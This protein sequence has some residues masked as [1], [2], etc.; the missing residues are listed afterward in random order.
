MSHTSLA[1]LD[2]RHLPEYDFKPRCAVGGDFYDY[3]TGK[4]TAT[5]PKNVEAF[6][7]LTEYGMRYDLAAI[8]E[9]YSRYG[10]YY[11]ADSALFQGA[12]FMQVLYSNTPGHAPMFAPELE[13]GHE[14]L[15][16]S[17]GQSL[18]FGRLGG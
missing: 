3:E 6:T 17:E 14:Y 4:V 18:P 11:A 10:K 8:N 2:L 13:L 12:E 5:D 16:A 9:F 1:P 7:W 15:P